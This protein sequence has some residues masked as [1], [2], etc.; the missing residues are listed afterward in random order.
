MQDQRTRSLVFL[1][2]IAAQVATWGTGTIACATEKQER[3]GFWFLYR[4]PLAGVFE[5]GFRFWFSDVEAKIQRR[6][7]EASGTKGEGEKNASALRAKHRRPC[8]SAT[9]VQAEAYA[10]Y[11]SFLKMP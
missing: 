5:V 1:F 9:W 7:P 3:G 8:L 2:C 11:C 4:R 10:T 6:R